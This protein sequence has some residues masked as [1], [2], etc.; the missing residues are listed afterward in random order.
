MYSACAH[1]AKRLKGQPSQAQ[2]LEMFARRI[3]PNLCEENF[4][5]LCTFLKNVLI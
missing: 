2:I 1:T 5:I 4:S 3:P